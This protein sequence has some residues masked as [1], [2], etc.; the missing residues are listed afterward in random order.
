MRDIGRT[1]LLI[2]LMFGCIPYIAIAMPIL[3]VGHALTK[4]QK[5][6]RPNLT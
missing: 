1:L 3:L 4:K 5:L 6:N 2:A